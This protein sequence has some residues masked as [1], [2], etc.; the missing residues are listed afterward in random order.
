M[1]N[2]TLILLAAC[3][4]TSNKSTPAPAPAAEQ[5]P[6]EMA[7]VQSMKPE[8]DACTDF[9]TYACGGW[10][11]AT[12]LPADRSIV[13]RSFTTI[14]DE[15]QA[16]IREILEGAAKDPGEDPVQQ[17]LGAYYGACMDEAAIETAGAMPLKPWL[18]KIAS[19]DR[20]GLWS[21]AGELT[22]FGPNPFLGAAIWADDKNPDLNIVHVGQDGLGMPDRSYY[23]ELDEKGEARK[24]DYQ[25]TIA[26]MLALAGVDAEKAK[27]DAAK[28]VAFETRL[29]EIQW[30][31]E[32]LRDSDKTY[33]KMT[34]DE[35]QALTPTFD[36]DG[37]FE[38]FGVDTEALNVR[39]P[40]YFQKLEPLLKDTKDDVLKAYLRW[41]LVRWAAP[42]LHEALDQRSFA[43]F[44]KQLSGQEEQQ[45]RWKRCVTRTE[46]AMGEW[47]GKAYVDRKF[48][49]D[50]KEQAEEMVAGI[51]AA[52]EK[53]LP[54][55]EW[56]DDATRERAV[57]KARA[58]IAKLGYPKK[59]RDYDALAVDAGDHFTNVVQANAFNLD[60]AVAKVDQP[61]DKDEWHMTPQTV[62]A[63]YNPAANEIVFPAGIMQAP[64]FDR[65]FP[66][67]MNYGALGMVIG[68]ELTHG[69]DDEGRK[70]APNGEL[71]EWWEP[72]VSARFEER[73][74]CVDDQY[75]GFTVD[76]GL[77]VNGK[78]TLG[79]NIADIGGLKMSYLAYQDWKEENGA[80]PEFAGLTGDQLVFV[81]FAQGWC[82]IAKPEIEEQRVKTDPHSPPRFRVNGTV[83]N[84]PQFAEAFGCEKG[85]PMAPEDYCEVW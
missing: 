82:T 25:T 83:M 49:G 58:F 47:L 71:K 42:Y 70:Y 33:N 85:S 20:A 73:A 28:V 63:Y 51:F 24:A 36:Y 30:P 16:I 4:G 6:A 48:A 8:V 59:Y 56:M 19:A 27:A 7:V 35:L 32:Q 50:S 78:L 15:N 1:R 11:D 67:A 44:A 68:H 17:K 12:E 60:H 46:S 45:P 31:R 79:E 40:S 76:E 80:E 9:Y 39:T 5:N 21:V 54:D 10:A 66:K 34:M 2:L 69:F 22:S 65:T 14:F 84:T 41:H 61:V 3:G 29:A 26:E 37:Y 52:F 57:E 38:Q 77:N 81:A 23:V 74:Q 64:F 72:E 13:T 75:S 55:L 43:F 53:N 62:N 18:D